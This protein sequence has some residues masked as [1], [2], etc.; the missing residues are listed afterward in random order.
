MDKKVN[1][2]LVYVLK[3]SDNRGIQ[4]ITVYARKAKS[5]TPVNEWANVNLVP[6]YLKNYSE[7]YRYLVENTSDD[8]LVAA[9]GETIPIKYYEISINSNKREVAFS[10]FVHKGRF[11]LI[12]VSNTGTYTKNAPFIQ[13]ELAT[14]LKL[15]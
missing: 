1:N 11:M 2:E 10:Y 7:G 9:S 15:F 13:N 6:V 12:I 4:K 3:A 8:S 5:N 14:G